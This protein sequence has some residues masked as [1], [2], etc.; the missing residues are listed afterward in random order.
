MDDLGTSH[1]RL[2]GERSRPVSDN[3]KVHV[4]LNQEGTISGSVYH[5]DPSHLSPRPWV[6]P[7][8]EPD[9]DGYFTQ[10]I[11]KPGSTLVDK[12]S[13]EL[14]GLTECKLC[15]RRRYLENKLDDV[16]VVTAVRGEQVSLKVNGKTCR[17]RVGQVFDPE[18]GKVMTMPAS[19][20]R[21][22][23]VE[24]TSDEGNDK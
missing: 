11:E 17:L 18:S 6:I 10:H 22:L 20:K 7:V 21:L 1:Q 9:S 24:V 16:V 13:A 5:T 8:G 4:T 12:G 23:G 19:L 15:H 2:A 14:F 3:D